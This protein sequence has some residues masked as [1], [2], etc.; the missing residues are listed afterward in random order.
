MTLLVKYGCQTEDLNYAS[1]SSVMS[2]FMSELFRS[3]NL[4]RWLID[5]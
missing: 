2:T 1:H 4:V 3:C 5:L